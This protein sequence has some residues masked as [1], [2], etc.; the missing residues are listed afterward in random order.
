VALGSADLLQDVP[1]NRAELQQPERAPA[2]DARLAVEERTAILPR[3]EHVDGH[4]GQQG[5]EDRGEKRE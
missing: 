5:D 4:R 3:D 1:A 2:R